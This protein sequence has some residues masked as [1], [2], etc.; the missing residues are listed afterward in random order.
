[1]NIED[2]IKTAKE[3]RENAYVPYSHYSV[4]AA[5]VTKS[6]QNIFWMQC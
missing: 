5:L 1:M 6:R 4:G 2:A 3:V